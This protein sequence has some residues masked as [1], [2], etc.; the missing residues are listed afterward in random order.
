LAE[1]LEVSIC[2]SSSVLRLCR[3]R[4][5]RTTAGALVVAHTD[6]GRLRHVLE[7]AHAVAQLF[8]GECY[9]EA[10]A[11]RASLVASTGRH[12]VV[13][14]AAHAEA[15]LDNP[16]FAHVKL[17]DGQLTTSDAFTLPLDGALV[18]LSACETGRG[19]VTAG[20]ELIGLSRGFLFAGATA[21]VQSLWR[22]EDGS[23]TQLMTRFYQLLR[24]GHGV[25]SALRQAQLG[26]LH[27]GVAHP[28]S[29]A[30]FQVVGAGTTSWV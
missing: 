23:T 15:R 24:A 25:G 12:G 17:A 7:E 30:P 21:I 28:F 20:D 4:P 1:R 3:E 22:V 27:A 16:D 14:L 10:E 18:T 13:H 5:R 6:D 26:L 2:P 8:P 11:T 9:V 29:W 19:I